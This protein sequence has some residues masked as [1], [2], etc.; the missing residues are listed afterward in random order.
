M[1]AG[2]T[3]NTQTMLRNTPLAITIPMSAPILKLIKSSISIP[4][5]VV[6]ALDEIDGNAFTHAVFIASS[7]SGSV[8]RSCR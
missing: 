1:S 6:S 7:R 8:A 2:K 4:A 3:V 5:T